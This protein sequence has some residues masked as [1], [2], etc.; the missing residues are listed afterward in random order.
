M[1]RWHNHV[2]VPML[3]VSSSADVRCPLGRLRISVF[4]RPL[5]CSRST[6]NAVHIAKIDP[7]ISIDKTICVPIR[8]EPDRIHDSRRT[9]KWLHTYSSL[10]PF[11]HRSQFELEFPTEVRRGSRS[12]GPQASSCSYSQR[13][14]NISWDSVLFGQGQTFE[15]LWRGSER[16]G[17]KERDGTKPGVQQ[18][19]GWIVSLYSSTNGLLVN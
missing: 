17:W 6:S 19:T 5:V 4:Q 2:R 11:E 13:F 9:T 14:D 1:R 10:D 3:V 15:A 18:S 7:L 8:T 16:T 12:T